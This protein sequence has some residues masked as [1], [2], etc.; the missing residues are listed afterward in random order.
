MPERFLTSH[1]ASLDDECVVL[2]RRALGAALNRF[3]SVDGPDERSLAPVDASTA[4]GAV[5]I[6]LDRVPSGPERDEAVA[7]L[8][9]RIRSSGG[10]TG[11]SAGEA[12]PAT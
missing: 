7:M 8:R 1:D 12:D 2:A 10:P 11:P 5:A 6:L 4:R 9:R 3:W